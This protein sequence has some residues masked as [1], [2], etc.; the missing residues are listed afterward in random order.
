ME[1]SNGNKHKEEE[2]TL[3]YD[4]NAVPWWTS[5]R[6]ALAVLGF[7]GF[8]NVYALRINMSIAIVCMVNHT[9]IKGLEAAA[10][11]SSNGTIIS[12]S[13][14]SRCGLLTTDE[15]GNLTTTSKNA[16][17]EFVWEEQTQGFILGSFFWGY[18]LT[19][20]PGG[21]LAT[22]IGGKRIFGYSM[23][24]ATIATFLT[25]VGAQTHY[26]FLIVLRVIVGIA[27]GV[28]YPSMHAIWGNWAP[29]M[30]RSK[31]VSFTYAGAQ[32]G[33]VVTFPLAGMLCKYG[34]AGGWPSIFYV[35]GILSMVWFVLWMIFVSDSPNQH[36]RISHAEKSYI[37]HSLSRTSK[38]EE[39][40]SVSVPWCNFAKSMPVMAILVANITTDWGL[41]TLLTKIPSY[42]S[43][44]LHLDIQ[45]NGLYSALPYLVLWLTINASGW[46]ADF[47][48]SKGCM[49]LVV[50]R[51]SFTLFGMLVPAV[52]LIGLGYVDCTQPNVAI[53]LLVLGVSL[54]G[55]QYSG[56]VVNHMDIA[57]AFAGVLFGISNSIAAVTGFL[58]P[59]VAGVLTEEKTREN[60][61]KVFYVAA[62]VYVFGAVFYAIFAS[63]TVQAW[64]VTKETTEH[65]EEVN[66][67]LLDY[68][69]T[70]GTKKDLENGK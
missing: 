15:S 37:A 53:T 68:K 29:P 34:F 57:P 24:L 62:G 48:Q 1:L 4:P 16:D 14:A 63:G 54:S 43:D 66:V 38:D 25:P 39:N 42:M 27:S 19:Q 18:L 49:S 67:E 33:N 6:L 51:K 20:I 21:W 46:L 9:A 11:T 36:R 50:T 35:L 26:V 60:W 32:V 13:E 10:N 31:L 5:C 47:L 69:A 65:G 7:F 55:A 3:D 61:Q 70:N 40:K 17:G 52:L 2:T 30:E 59:V 41:Y 22:K 56:W 8:L 44:V 45:A 64:A 58:S 23:L 28:C 12:A